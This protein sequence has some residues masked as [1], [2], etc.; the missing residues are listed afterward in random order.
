ME[1]WKDFLICHIHHW[2][3]SPEVSL[4]TEKGLEHHLNTMKLVDDPS[5]VR[6]ERNCRIFSHVAAIPSCLELEDE[7]AFFG[8]CG[9]HHRRARHCAFTCGWVTDRVGACQEVHDV[10]YLHLSSTSRPI[11]SLADDISIH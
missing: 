1:G 11:N 2:H 3:Q 4:K 6:T 8:V 9:V 5:R 10:H 7:T